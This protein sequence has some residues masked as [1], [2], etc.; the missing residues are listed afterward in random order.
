MSGK[1]HQTILVFLL[2]S[3]KQDRTSLVNLRF[4]RYLGYLS[5]Q[6][7]REAKLGDNP[8]VLSIYFMLRV[9]RTFEDKLILM[10]KTLRIF[11]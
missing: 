5:T 6:K 4:F 3:S 11:L 8:I 9:G 1:K 7:E 10:R 2:E